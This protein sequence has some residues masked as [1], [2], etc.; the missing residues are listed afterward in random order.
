MAKRDPAG[1]TRFNWALAVLGLAIIATLFC[2]LQFSTPE[3]CCSDFD[4]YYH[5]HWSQQ[6]WNGIRHGHFSPAFS[7]LPL[8]SLNARDYA[9]QH[10]LFHLLLIPF[11]W[12][13]TPVTA[14][15][16][17]AALF[18]T[19]A[20]FSCF[21]LSLRYRLRYPM[22]WLL[23]LLSSS[24]LFLYRMSMTRA[25]SLSII[26]IV[27]GIVLL[28][29]EKYRWLA[30]VG[31]FY[32]W[33]YNLF[34]ILAAMAVLWTAVLWWNERRRELRPI[35]WTAVGIAAGLVVNP[36]FPHDFRLFYEHLT[37]K[38]GEVST[39]SGA[40]MEWSAL[41]SSDLVKWNALAV[42]AML[43]G[44]LASGFLLGRRGRSGT[45]RPIFFL[46]FSTLLLLLAARSRRFVE[47]WPP[48]A[49][50]FAAF[51]LQ[52]VWEPLPQRPQPPKAKSG[53]TQ[54]A[55]PGITK[56]TAVL[57]VIALGGVFFYQARHARQL[58]ATP[59]GA[60]N[61]HAGTQWLLDHVPKGATIFNPAW[62]DFPILFYYDDAHAYVSGLDPIYLGNQNPDLGRLYERISAGKESHAGQ[63]IHQAFGADYVLVSPPVERNFYVAAMLSGEFSKVYEDKYCIILKVRNLDSFS[64]E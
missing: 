29:E 28:F 2:W 6:L 3:I 14:A 53:P 44:Y 39:T 47:Y 51:T 13:A 33:T 43:A 22:F 63:Y 49:I 1:S 12:F 48:F 40:G 57:L 27:A 16:I 30:V 9:D 32:A 64:S 61:Y 36:Y 42:V 59:S 26:F 38:L 35:L 31:F 54:T 25:Q 19:A 60:E 55:Q 23:A 37:A 45:Q 62:D 5:I 24:A 34:V 46:L 41:P 18:A 15:K 4:G 56:A 11:L 17:S 21:W 58:I 10:L 50:L 20:V 52:A 8:T 7:W